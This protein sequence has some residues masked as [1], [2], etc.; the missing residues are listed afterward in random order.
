MEDSHINVSRN[1][2]VLTV[3]LNRPEVHNAQ[4]PAMWRAFA[5]ICATLTPEVRVVL[6]QAEGESFSA[7][8]DRRMLTAE[9][10]EGEQTFSELAR[11]NDAD[12]SSELA[13]FQAGF[14]CWRNPQFISVAAVQGHAIGAGF[15]LALA[16]DLRVVADDVG[17]VMKET[18]LGLVPDLGG[19]KT[20]TEMVG[21]ARALEMCA[22]SRKVG[23]TEAVAIGLANAAVPRSDLSGTVH[24][25]ID[26]LLV[27]DHDAVIALKGLLIDAGEHSSDEQ[28]KRE[29]L[30]Q[31]DRFRAH[32][33]N[34][35]G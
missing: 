4:T 8:L 31:A 10:I 24:D 21:R 12:I 25:L 14:T 22:T 5:D 19:T 16:C 30:A 20:L 35:R 9:G 18:A 29:R 15:Q 34:R 13:K 3:T 27:P 23:A 33:D 7:G 1:G 11:L 17:F 26:A 6:I 2:P 28:L 32:L